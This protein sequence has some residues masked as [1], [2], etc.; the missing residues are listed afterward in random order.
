MWDH[1]YTFKTLIITQIVEVFLFRANTYARTILLKA[2][3]SLIC[4][5][6]ILLNT[7]EF[8]KAVMDHLKFIETLI[9]KGIEKVNICTAQIYAQTNLIYHSKTFLDVNK[10]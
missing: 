7:I 8:Q 1:F 5:Q 2:L 6:I 4:T 3:L 9:N 10:C